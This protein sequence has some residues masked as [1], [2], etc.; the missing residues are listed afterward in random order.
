M[1]SD[2]EKL[3]VSDWYDYRLP[4]ESGSIC[5]PSAGFTKRVFPVQWD[6]SGGHD[7]VC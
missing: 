2:E 4:L 6:K 1:F 5:D 7:L 3:L